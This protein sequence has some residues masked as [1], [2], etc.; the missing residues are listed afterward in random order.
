MEDIIKSISD[1]CATMM[2]FCISRSTKSLVKNLLPKVVSNIERNPITINKRLISTGLGHKKSTNEENISTVIA[3][4]ISD[5]IFIEKI[6]LLND[7][8]KYKIANL[9]SDL[10]KEAILLTPTQ[11]DTVNDRLGDIF[12]FRAGTIVFWGVS[13]NNQKRLLDKLAHLR[14]D[15]NSYEL[16]QEEGEY[17]KFVIDKSC[18]RSRLYRDTV[19]L[20]DYKDVSSRHIDQF[21]ISHAIASSVKLAVWELSLDNYL[22]SINWIT[23]RMKNGH[24]LNLSR[25]Q[26]FRKTG[27]IYQLKH[28]IISSDLLDL[29]DV[30]WDRYYQEVLYLSIVS[31]LNI[32]KR[33]AVMNEKLNNCCELM[34]LLATHMSDK[35]HVRLEWMIIVL[36]LIEVIFEMVK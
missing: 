18:D 13:S 23:N 3:L 25:S 10:V 26:V 35:H 4:N 8:D 12:I 19:Q 27:E 1:T 21:A 5:S 15:P 29:P 17:L 2:A 16:A 36:I 33:T 30:Y 34:N 31:F 6:K 22:D 32:K 20:A 7:F 24:H 28:K 14:V 11:H 9:P